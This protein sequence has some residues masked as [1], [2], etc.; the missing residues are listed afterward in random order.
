MQ[1]K[2]KEFARNVVIVSLGPIIISILGFFLEPWIA[3]LWSP[4]IIGIGA[5][6]N[7]LLQILTPAMFLR[8]NFAIVQAETDEEAHNLFFL[9]LIVTTKSLQHS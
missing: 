6:F 9:S 7:S 5:Y 4:E 8:Y 1:R 2:N 3:R